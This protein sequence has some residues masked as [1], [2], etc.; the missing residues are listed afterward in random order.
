M[1]FQFYL[2]KL[3]N[4]EEYVNFKKEFSDAF[5]TSGFISVDKEKKG[6]DQFH[7]DFYVPS[8]NKLFSFKLEDGVVKVPIETLEQ[9]NFFE[10]SDNL[11][12]NMNEIEGMIAY[13]IDK[14][15]LKKTIKNY[16]FIEKKDGK[17]YLIFDCFFSVIWSD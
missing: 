1:N 12:F 17:N 4:S 9:Q 14:Q 11:D 5:L 15:K 13:E 7:L 2:E 16:V 3:F 10:I 6:Q 8:A